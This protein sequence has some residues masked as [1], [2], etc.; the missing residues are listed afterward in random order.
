MLYLKPGNPYKPTYPPEY[1]GSNYYDA[2]ATGAGL[3]D[4][5]LFAR[6]AAQM[7]VENVEGEKHDI[8]GRSS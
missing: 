2:P 6:Q 4:E 1:D 3:M 8:L 5:D 7:Q